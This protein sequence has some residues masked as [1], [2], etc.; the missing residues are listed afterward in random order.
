MSDQIGMIELNRFL[1]Q[2]AERYDIASKIAVTSS[3]NPEGP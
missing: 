1:T 2:N 3:L